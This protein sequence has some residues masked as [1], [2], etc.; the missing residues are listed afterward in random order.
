MGKIACIYGST[1]L[2]GSYLLDVL[3]SD[4]RYSKIIVFNR[5]QISLSNPKIEQIVS[6]YTDLERHRPQLM[7]DEY[8]C[9]LG[10]TMA[11]AKTKPAFEY[12]DYQLPIE[13]GKIALHHNVRAYLVVSSIGASAK[14]GN[15][16]LCTKGKME[17]A[18]STIGLESLFIFRP[19]M[20]LGK[21]N[22]TRIMESVSKPVFY[23]LGFLLWGPFKKYRAIHGKTV[24]KA[25]VN[26]ANNHSGYQ[27]FESDKIEKLA[28]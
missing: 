1:G 4:E 7:A 2:I 14:S 12:V 9:C 16:Y 23:L 20:L 3:V 8:Y 28:Y 27:T 22:E 21:R 18:I 26:C 5:S 13:I 24:A 10:T 11:K 19:S 17:E 25:M 15:F 6:D